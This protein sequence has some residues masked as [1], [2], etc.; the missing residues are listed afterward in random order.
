MCRGQKGQLSGFGFVIHQE[1][2]RE[3]TQAVELGG[4]W[5]YPLSGDKLKQTNTAR[6]WMSRNFILVE[7]IGEIDNKKQTQSSKIYI[8][9]EKT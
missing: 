6:F 1:G 9:L 3:Q 5:A 8:V 7:G 4:K 2:S